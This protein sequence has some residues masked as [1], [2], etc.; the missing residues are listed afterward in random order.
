MWGQRRIDTGVVKGTFGGKE[1]WSGPALTGAI[2]DFPTVTGIWNSCAIS[3]APVDNRPLTDKLHHLK[4]MWHV[5]CDMWHVTRYTWQVTGDRW[6]MTY[7]MLWGVYILSK[8][9][10]PS[11]SVLWY[12]IFWRLEGKGS[13][14]HSLNEQINHE[15]DCRTASARP[16]LLNRCGVINSV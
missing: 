6:H 7:D 15:A 11:C 10:L 14:T 5:T 12:M 3:V 13:P 1:P 8:F 16:G 2:W 9:R 4:K